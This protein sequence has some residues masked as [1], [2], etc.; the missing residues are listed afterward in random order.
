MQLFKVPYTYVIAS[1]DIKIST[2]AQH[3]YF[4]LNML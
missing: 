3:M 2:A 4:V 1:E